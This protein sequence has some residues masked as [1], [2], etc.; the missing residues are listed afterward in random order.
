MYFFVRLLGERFHVL[1]FIQMR[2]Y[3]LF[4]DIAPIAKG[5]T[6]IIPRE[7]YENLFKMPVELG[8]E[9]LQVMQK[10]G[11]AIMKQLVPQE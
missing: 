5:H 4:L 2:T 11:S 9:L 7:H 1:K 6:L 8:S 3:W 10:V